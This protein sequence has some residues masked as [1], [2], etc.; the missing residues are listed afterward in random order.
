MESKYALSII[1]KD[2]FQKFIKW[3]FM[4]KCVKF[5][6]VKV[7]LKRIIIQDLIY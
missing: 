5:L 6:N 1:K 4:R 3:A 2:S 7:V